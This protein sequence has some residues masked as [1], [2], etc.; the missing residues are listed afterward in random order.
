MSNGIIPVSFPLAGAGVTNHVF[1]PY[2]VYRVPGAPAGAI[3][4]S[5]WVEKVVVDPD[6][7]VAF[8]QIFLVKVF[9]N[10]TA[11]GAPNF[12]AGLAPYE[13]SFTGPLA[14]EGAGTHPY[15]RNLTSP[16]YPEEALV[17]AQTI[18]AA[19]TAN[20]GVK[21]VEIPVGRNFPAGVVVVVEV[22]AAITLTSLRCTV[23]MAPEVPGF[24]R[25]KQQSAAHLV[26]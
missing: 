12:S 7:A 24:M 5:G 19:L 23:H 4:G 17:V 11:A 1:L 3:V 22:T 15:G 25:L 21:P 26:H 20:E 6:A 14:L 9:H 18:G 10:I 16:A 8:G 13:L 2:G